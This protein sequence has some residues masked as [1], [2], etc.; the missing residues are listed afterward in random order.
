MCTHYREIVAKSCLV[1]GIFLGCD[2]VE[3]KK[4]KALWIGER[5]WVITNENAVKIVTGLI[6]QKDLTAVVII[7]QEDNEFIDKE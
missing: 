6:V 5:N 1:N 4:L 7:N 3:L 2:Q